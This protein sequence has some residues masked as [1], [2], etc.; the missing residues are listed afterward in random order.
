VAT[1]DGSIV[2]SYTGPDAEQM[3]VGGELNKLAS[4]V[5]FGRIFSGI[6]WRSD[7]AQGMQLGEAVAISLLRDQAGL[8]NEDYHGF[9]F[10]KFNGE[11]ITV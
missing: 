5:G 10:T 4:N 1:P 2:T 8:Y 3:T 7:V 6:H 9:T 11:K